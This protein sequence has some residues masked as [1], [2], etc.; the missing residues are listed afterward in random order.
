MCNRFG[1]IPTTDVNANP[2]VCTQDVCLIDN[3]TINII[4]AEIAGG[5]NFNQVCNNCAGGNCSC[6]V[7]GLTIDV[8]NET[9]NGNVVPVGQGCGNVSCT[10]SNPANTGP[11]NIPVPCGTGPQ[12]P[13]TQYEEELAAAKAAAQKSSWFWT[14]VVIA[15][16]LIL[17]F[18]IILLLHPAYKN[19]VRADRE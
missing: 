16:G 6:I 3:I 15:A 2:I 7:D 18:L 10:Q 9:I 11:D 1:T 14:L 8:A 13:Y 5:L 12:N 17:I 19:M 4:N